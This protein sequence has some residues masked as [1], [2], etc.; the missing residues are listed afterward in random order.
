MSEKAAQPESALNNSVS[1]ALGLLDQNRLAGIISQNFLTGPEESAGQTDNTTE[2]E[3]KPAQESEQE[4]EVEEVLS[5]SEEEANEEEQEQ[6]PEEEQSSEEPEEEHDGLPRGVQKRIS[7]LVAKQKAA[8][9]E[10]EAALAKVKQ[11]EQ[12]LEAAKKADAPKPS[13]QVSD[14]VASLESV[15]DVEREFNNAVDVILW[16]EENPDGA[17][18]KLADGTERELS[19]E[20]IRAMRKTAIRRKDVELPARRRFLEQQTAYEQATVQEYG[21]WKKP[22]SAEYQVAQ[23]VIRDFPELRKRPDWK[24]IA[25]VFVEGLAARQARLKKAAAPKQEA[26]KRAPSQP[27]VSVAKAK[28]SGAEQKQ[29]IINKFA[30]NP[31]S[32]SLSEVLKQ[33]GI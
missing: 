15:D 16:T 24:H 13:V 31:T 32:Q 2:V 18:I 1:N 23:Q 33:I 7:K 30:S 26:P 9:E 17:V 5:Q 28:P 6:E 27:G 21:W 19:A 29:D 10:A 14:F 12:E 22:D 3:D 4:T 8:K 11:L 25:G 20:E